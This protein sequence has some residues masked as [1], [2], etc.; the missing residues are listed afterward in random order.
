ME[1]LLHAA[2]QMCVCV[3]LSLGVGVWLHVYGW[4]L[5]QLCHAG[6]RSWGQHDAWEYSS[7]TA[8]D[9]YFFLFYRM[10]DSS[11]MHLPALQGAINLPSWCRT[12]SVALHVAFANFSKYWHVCNTCKAAAGSLPHGTQTLLA[13]HTAAADG[14]DPTL[15]VADPAT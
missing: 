13:C 1:M 10:S 3:C 11:R 6:K 12:Y 15:P 14:A 9:Y 7:G 5:Q 2:V 4:F 8:R